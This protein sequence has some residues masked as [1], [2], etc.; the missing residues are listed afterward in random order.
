MLRRITLPRAVARHKIISVTSPEVSQE[1]VQTQR[2]A[3]PESQVPEPLSE[4]V[5]V[6]GSIDVVNEHV[7]D[8]VY[9][10]DD[11]K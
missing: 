5:N 1:R 6:P 9:T 3:D 8:P 2:D 11:P 4:P 7:D 10:S